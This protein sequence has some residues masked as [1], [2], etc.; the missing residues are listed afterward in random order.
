MQVT[1][2]K[3]HPMARAGLME[4]QAAGVDITPDIVLW[5]QDAAEKIRKTPLRPVAD[6]VDWPAMAG[7]LCSTRYPLGPWR[8]SWACRNA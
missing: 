7:V 3:L 5:V 6:L 2:P 8:G 4:I 1:K